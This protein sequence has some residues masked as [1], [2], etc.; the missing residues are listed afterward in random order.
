M[1][2]ENKSEFS[3]YNAL[4]DLILGNELKKLKY[5]AT[6]LKVIHSSTFPG[7]GS[8]LRNLST[9]CDNDGLSSEFENKQEKIVFEGAQNMHFHNGNTLVK[10]LDCYLLNT[11]VQFCRVC[12]ICT[13]ISHN[14]RP[15]K[16][17]MK[18][19]RVYGNISDTLLNS[20][21]TFNRRL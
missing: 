3:S 14:Y 13:L 9:G 7:N 2:A 18:G 5:T 10:K 11:L 4:I 1:L 16:D 20:F 15:V 21:S 6:I 19:T 17:V 12:M 8:C